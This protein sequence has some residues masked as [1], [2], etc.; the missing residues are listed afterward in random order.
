MNRF[1]NARIPYR[2]SM[3]CG[4]AYRACAVHRDDLRHSYKRVESAR[5]SQPS[6]FVA[7]AREQL[8]HLCRVK[9]S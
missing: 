3:N 2:A 1:T 4:V 7:V 9:V 8:R 6:D 5:A